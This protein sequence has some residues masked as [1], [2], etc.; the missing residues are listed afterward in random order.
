MAERAA[1]KG[2]FT[3]LTNQEARND[4]CPP[5][6]DDTIW[7]QSLTDNR[8]LQQKSCKKHASAP[9]WALSSPHKRQFWGKNVRNHTRNRNPTKKCIFWLSATRLARGHLICAHT[10][11]SLQTDK[12]KGA[13]TVP[14][15]A[16]LTGLSRAK[17]FFFPLQKNQT[18][19]PSLSYRQ[20][21]H[22]TLQE[23]CIKS[24]WLHAAWICTRSILEIGPSCLSM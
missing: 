21:S 16:L 12:G 19:P 22:N 15:T 1:A 24:E 6:G 9:S 4:S 17:F 5:P 23:E 3:H 10:Q 13:S 14:D 2:F 7:A 11:L 18:I 20:L 8:E